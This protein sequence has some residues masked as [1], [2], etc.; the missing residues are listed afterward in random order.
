MPLRLD[1]AA[2]SHVGMVRSGNE[3]SGYAGPHLLAVADGMGGAAFGEVASTTAL[4]AIVDALAGTAD[5]DSADPAALMRDAVA[6]AGDQIRT[7]VEGRPELEGMGT[8]LTM[9]LQLGDRMAI[10]QVGD[11]RG[12]LLRDGVLE[13]VTHDQ[14]FVQSLID[15]GRI[16]RADASL[17][18]Q[19][20]M[21]LQALD[22]R[23]EVEPDIVLRTP[24][25]GDRY[26]LCS[27][28]LSGVLS[29][30]TM[31]DVLS[32]GRP[33]DAVRDLLD[34]ALRGGAPDN[35]TCIVADLTED[36]TDEPEPDAL[37][38]GAAADLAGADDGPHPSE[39]RSSRSGSSH[40]RAGSA[41]GGHDTTG[42]TR[43]RARRIR[44]FGPLLVVVVVTL[45]LAGFGGYRWTQSQYYVAAAGADVAIYQG[46][47]QRIFGYSLSRVVQRGGIN[48]ESL[49][50]FARQQLGAT[51]QA[52]DLEHARTIL[53]TL[54]TEAQGCLQVP[55]PA[56]C[57][58]SA[59]SNG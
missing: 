2:S 36:A 45:G 28:G 32:A 33:A 6:K 19:R 24:R 23:V 46:V 4:R 12:Y 57:P 56:G 27:D 21:L 53:D 1:F 8:T 43:T 22:G 37:V 11:S 47:P 44:L 25:D 34:L 49:P 58:G 41:G 15:Q 38:V 20:N 7:L 18:P 14:T 55:A 54:R 9:L 17:H 59:G 30:A 10:G 26:L 42:E 40:R 51:I 39:Q 52:D 5:Y 35:V 29:E 16:S 31:R 3:D 13:Q 48:P 50:D